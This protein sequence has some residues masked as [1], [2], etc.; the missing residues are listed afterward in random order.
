MRQ[1]DPLD[2]EGVAGFEPGEEIEIAVTG[3]RPGERL[4]EILTRFRAQAGDFEAGDG[5]ESPAGRD[6]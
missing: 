3:S 5:V 2:G 4:N 1:Q 6:R